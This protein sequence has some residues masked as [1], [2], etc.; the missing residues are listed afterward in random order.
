MREGLEET[1]TVLAL[2]ITGAL[3]RLLRTTNPIEDLNGFIAHITRKRQKMHGQRD[4]IA[5]GGRRF[6]RF[7]GALPQ[8][9]RASGNEVPDAGFGDAAHCRAGQQKQSGAASRQTGR[10]PAPFNSDRDIACLSGRASCS[11]NVALTKPRHAKSPN[12]KWLCYH[13]LIFNT[14]VLLCGTM[15]LCPLMLKRM[16]MP[17]ERL[18][19]VRAGESGPAQKFLFACSRHSVLL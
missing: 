6:E 8:A 18:H 3:Y 1:L 7:Q 11:N 15:S 17:P 12:I 14:S 9:A 5:L 16:L 13:V 19:A 4:D 2:G 10:H